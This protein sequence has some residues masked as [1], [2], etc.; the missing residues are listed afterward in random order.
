MTVEPRRYVPVVRCLI[1]AVAASAT[2]GVTGCGGDNP[3]R[4]AGTIELPAKE[5]GRFNPKSYVKGQP[6]RKAQ[7]P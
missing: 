6:V 1:V 2:L 4:M 7:T 3:A 5:E